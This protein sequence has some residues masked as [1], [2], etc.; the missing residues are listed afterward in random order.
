MPEY[1][2]TL[3]LSEASESY[4]GSDCLALICHSPPRDCA[5]ASAL[6]SGGFQV[7]LPRANPFWFKSR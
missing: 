7:S 2:M 4:T 1:F 3:T 5:V 6:E